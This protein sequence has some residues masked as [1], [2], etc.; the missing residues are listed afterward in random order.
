MGSQLQAKLTQT[1][2]TQPLLKK[3][4]V[5]AYVTELQ[6]KLNQAGAEPTLIED[7]IFGTKTDGAVKIFQ[8]NLPRQ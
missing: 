4:S 7:G 3:G 8:D 1:N 2:G 5:G 6:Q